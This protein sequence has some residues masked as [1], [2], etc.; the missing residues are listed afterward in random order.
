ME[1][2]QYQ[3]YFGVNAAEVQEA[4]TFE[5]PNLLVLEQLE[6]ALAPVQEFE[7]ISPV[8]AQNGEQNPFQVAKKKMFPA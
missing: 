4:C 5:I 2:G 3:S 6:E 8:L 7:V 1:A